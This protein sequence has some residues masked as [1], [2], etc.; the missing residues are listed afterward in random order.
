M[1]KI[2]VLI[3]ILSGCATTQQQHGYFDGVIDSGVLDYTD[4]D[5][6]ETRH[7]K[8]TMQNII[9]KA[10]ISAETAQ[11]HRDAILRDSAVSVHQT[12]VRGRIIAVLILI[13]A[14]SAAGMYLKN[15]YL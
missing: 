5:T 14:G 15:R 12:K 6:E 13:V 9:G 7:L 11:E 4:S 3:F 1:F 8:T 10:K 2:I